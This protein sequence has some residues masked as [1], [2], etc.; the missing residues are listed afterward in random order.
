M[1]REQPEGYRVPQQSHRTPAN[2]LDL[3]L[4]LT[5]TIW[6]GSEISEELRDTLTAY[7][8]VT[9]KTGN[10]QYDEH[11]RV[12]VR[13]VILSD[14][15]KTQSRDTRLGNL[16]SSEMTTAHHYNELANDL[17]MTGYHFP[18]SVG[19]CIGRRDSLLNL[20]Q[21]RKGWFRKILQSVFS[22][23]HNI[24]SQGPKKSALSLKGG[25]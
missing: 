9:D 25:S 13:E 21:S 23:T 2:D 3:N 8:E 10:L 4:M 11:G 18:K 24:E 6:D 22:E 17:L 20:S 1:N 12:I 15:L 16:D 5:N 14:R 7:V 19:T